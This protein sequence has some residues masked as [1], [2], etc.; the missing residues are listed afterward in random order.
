METI[1][2]D[3]ANKLKEDIKLFYQQLKTGCF[4]KVCYNN[5]CAKGNG[6]HS[7]NF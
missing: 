1:K 6:K 4:R 3:I 7:L 2:S 5:F